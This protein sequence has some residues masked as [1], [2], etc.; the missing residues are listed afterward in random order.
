MTKRAKRPNV[1]RL[2]KPT[3]PT[4]AER[5]RKDA[6][7]EADRQV[8]AARDRQVIEAAARAQVA[9]GREE[10][11]AAAQCAP[12]LDG[13]AVRRRHRGHRVGAEPLI[14][15]FGVIGV[16]TCVIVGLIVWAVRTPPPPESHD[17]KG[18]WDE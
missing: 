17:V 5:A 3:P 8:L 16:L 15:T 4:P 9:R 12:R 7:D 10:A 13:G 2:R 6:E 18:L 14:W 11:R 1:V